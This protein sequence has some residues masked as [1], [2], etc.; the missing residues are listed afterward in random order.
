[1][2]NHQGIVQGEENIVCYLEKIGNEL[3][4]KNGIVEE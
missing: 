3:V 4:K 1:M 2:F